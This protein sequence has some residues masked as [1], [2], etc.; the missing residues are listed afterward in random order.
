MGQWRWLERS[1]GSRLPGLLQINFN[2]TKSLD[3]I[4][5]LTL[6]DDYSNPVEPT[7]SQTF[8][9]YGITD[10]NVQYWDGGAWL[11]V[12]NGHVT[13]NNLVWRQFVFSPIVTSC[14]RVLINNSLQTYSRIAEVEA[15]GVGSTEIVPPPRTRP[16]VALAANGASASASSIYTG[17]TGY[18]ISAI[19]DGERA[20]L[21]WGNGGGWNDDT[22]NVYP[23]WAQVDFQG[24]KTINLINV[25]TLQDNYGAPSEPTEMQIFTQYGITDFDVQY[26]DG[27]TWVNIPVGNVTDNNRVW[28]SLSFAAVT[29]TK[30]R[31][32]VN[33]S[34]QSYSRI[35]EIEAYEVEENSPSV[36]ITAPVQNATYSESATINVEVEASATQ[37]ALRKIEFF[38]RHDKLGETTVAPYSFTWSD[39]PAGNHLLTARAT[40]TFG[41]TTT[42][43]AVNISVTGPFSG[44][45]NVARA[46]NGGT[47]SASST[48]NNNFSVSGAIDGDRN[49]NNWGNGGGW[50]DATANAYPDWLQVDFDGTKTLNEI[51]VFTVQDNYSN[52]SAPSPGMTFTQYGITDFELQYWDGTVW[53]TAPSTQVTG[54]NLVKRHFSVTGLTTPSIRLVVNNSLGGYSR[55][56][57]LEAFGVPS[58]QT[59]APP[60][61]NVALMSRGA[62]ITAS[63]AYNSGGYPVSAV[64]DGDRRGSNWGAGGG[65][66]DDTAN[67]YPDWLEIDFGGD[68]TINEI[69]VF[70]LQD[71]YGNPIDPTETMTFLQYGITDFTIQYW[72]GNNWLPLSGGAVNGNNYVWRKFSFAEITTRKIK[73]EIHNSLANYSRITE[74]E[75][76]GH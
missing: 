48:Y 29:T 24:P 9:Q 46:T 67:T 55:V 32:L 61:T 75:V 59:I 36:S 23:D 42:S 69:D 26:W 74:I 21:N 1:D 13:G 53:V 11:D 60:P 49:G 33:G 54:N 64:I 14:I 22:I 56:A 20:G 6:Q 25:F 52:P 4:N 39:V 47:A 70:T 41:R 71:D 68:K 3:E 43:S 62:T 34:L 19:I 45:T 30:I 51:N 63:S 16:N 58:T 28:R 17:S 72:D 65:W 18:P 31:V 44:A 15:Y 50:N 5:V 37:G 57:E 10:F 76:Y 7:T 2:G 12:P 27:N 8:S 66:N 73:V 38:N 40:D 35:T